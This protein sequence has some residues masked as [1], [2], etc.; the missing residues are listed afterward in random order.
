MLLPPRIAP[1]LHTNQMAEERGTPPLLPHGCIAPSGKRQLKPAPSTRTTRG[2]RERE[3]APPLLPS[4]AAPHRA[5]IAPCTE[6]VCASTAAYR[7]DA[8]RPMHT[9]TAYV[10]R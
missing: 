4:T 7:I 1:Q 6:P 2:R 10:L 5:T 8:A 3:H 9:A